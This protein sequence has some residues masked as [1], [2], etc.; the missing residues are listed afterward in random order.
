MI[1]LYQQHD[2]GNCCKLPNNGQSWPEASD[3]NAVG[4]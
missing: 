2:S 1:T 4:V 3:I